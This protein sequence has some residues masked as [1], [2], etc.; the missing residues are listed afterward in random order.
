MVGVSVLL[1]RF[2]PNRGRRYLQTALL[3]AVLATVVALPMIYLRGSQPPVKAL[4]LQDY[5]LNLTLILIAAITLSLYA[6]HVA[7]DNSP[8][9]P[10]IQSDELPP[11]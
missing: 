2:V 1:R 9:E 4:L 5:G 10:D 6:I 8:P 3:V 7:R 11:S